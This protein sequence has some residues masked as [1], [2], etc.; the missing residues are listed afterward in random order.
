MNRRF[1]AVVA[2]LLIP[3]MLALAACGGPS[4]EEYAE[5]LEEICADVEN[6]VEDIGAAQATSPQELSNQIDRMRDA[7][8]EGVEQMKD[9][10]RPSG[11]DGEKAEEY[12]NRVEQSVNEELLP[13]L[14][15]LEQAVQEEDEVQLRAAAR[16]LDSID[17]EEQ[18]ELAR[19]IGADRCAED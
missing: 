4:R 10:E 11:E 8:K 7:A 14:D 2:A 3:A 17:D 12:V 6:R 18:K 5:D 13:A 9:L 16:R 19:D 15:E 1:L